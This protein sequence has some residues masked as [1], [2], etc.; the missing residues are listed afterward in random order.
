MF[1]LDIMFDFSSLVN[2]RESNNYQVILGRACLLIS[3][4]IWCAARSSCMHGDHVDLPN[5]ITSSA[6]QLLHHSPTLYTTTS[7]LANSALCTTSRVSN[8][9]RFPLRHVEI[10]SH[11]NARYAAAS[12]VITTSSASQQAS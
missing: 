8:T 3:T 10:L 7:C 12:V 9:V 4:N 5:S 6:T 11:L 2:A 1:F